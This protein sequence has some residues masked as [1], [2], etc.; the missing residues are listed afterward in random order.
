MLL[1]LIV[2]ALIGAAPRPDRAPT[3]AAKAAR[4]PKKR[5]T[6]LERISQKATNWIREY[7]SKTTNT[8]RRAQQ[9]RSIW[10]AH[11]DR[12]V[13]KSDKNA[14]SGHSLMPH[15][16]KLFWALHH[17]NARSLSH[18]KPLLSFASNFGLFKPFFTLPQTCMPVMSQLGCY[19]FA[20]H[21]QKCHNLCNFADVYTA[22]AGKISPL[23]FTHWASSLLCP[24]ACNLFE[25]EAALAMPWDH[26][27]PPCFSGG[28]CLPSLRA[29]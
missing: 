27:Q 15:S 11:S 8:F 14:R 24:L 19:S 5:Q 18:A 10:Q 22:F 26:T 20:C 1:S 13:Q 2:V 12:I 23:F 3:K 9:S 16:H 28:F 7:T 21:C 25:L 4:P 17:N 29:Q 6:Y